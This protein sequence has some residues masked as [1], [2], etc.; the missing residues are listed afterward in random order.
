MNKTVSE[1]ILEG[2]RSIWDEFNT[3]PFVLGIANGTLDI[4]KFKFFMIQ[5]YLYLQEYAKVFAIGAA[6]ASDS[7][8]MKAF[9][10]YVSAIQSGEMD[11]HK[12][13]MSKLGISTSEVENARRSQDNLSYT[14]YML[15]IAYEGGPAEVCAAILPCALSY[16]EIAKQM[17]SADPECDKHPF[18]GEW[19]RGYAGSGY[20]EENIA[21]MA[22]TEIAASGYCGEKIK[23]LVE[24]GNRCSLYEK[25]FWD[26]SW[27]MRR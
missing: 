21:L 22:L 24:I 19:I 14:S 11:I 13:Y 25:A 17:I 2:S 20:H 15:R 12:S 3:H 4:E 5:D 7:F 27:E 16:E 18:Y 23:A 9:T 26:M 8:V 1:R 6:K 10:S